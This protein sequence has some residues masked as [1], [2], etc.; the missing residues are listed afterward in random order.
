MRC[1]ATVNFYVAFYENRAWVIFASKFALDPSYDWS[2]VQFPEFG[3]VGSRHTGGDLYLTFTTLFFSTPSS[4]YVL[5][6]SCIA[7]NSMLPCSKLRKLLFSDV[8]VGGLDFSVNLFLLASKSCLFCFIWRPLPPLRPFITRR[9]P[10]FMVRGIGEKNF[11]VV[12]DA[13]WSTRMFDTVS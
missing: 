4:V 13:I 11:R 12:W 3:L 5:T 7:P 8:T 10:S 6:L 2:S 1:G 9:A